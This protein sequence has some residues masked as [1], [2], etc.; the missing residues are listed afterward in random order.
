VRSLHPCPCVRAC[1][2][3][4]CDVICSGLSRCRQLRALTRPRTPSS[5]NSRGCHSWSS[6]FSNILLQHKKVYTMLK[7]KPM[8]NL[9]APKG[10]LPF[11]PIT[12]AAPRMHR[13]LHSVLDPALTSACSAEC[14]PCSE[15]CLTAM[16]TCPTFARRVMCVSNLQ[17][18]A[19]VHPL[20][21]LSTSTSA[22]TNHQQ[23]HTQHTQ[24]QQH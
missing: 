9:G 8:L 3:R 23:Q 7:N 2:V 20:T 6:T 4:A 14:C 13:E 1:C 16:N 19:A 11:K 5:S 12:P 15:P 10:S 24:H 22:S 18:C 21:A 17:T